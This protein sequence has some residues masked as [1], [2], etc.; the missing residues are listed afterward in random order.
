MVKKYNLPI[1]RQIPITAVINT[2]YENKLPS[3]NSIIMP[4]FT[5]PATN[6]HFI[7][8]NKKGKRRGRKN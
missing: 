6:K 3:Q 4:V 2:R 8:P 5:V 1:L 7:C